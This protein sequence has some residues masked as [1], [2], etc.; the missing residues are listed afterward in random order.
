MLAASAAVFALAVLAALL[1]SLQAG[2]Q[3]GSGDTRITSLEGDVDV[4]F[5]GE[6]EW[7]PAE[8]DT[9]LDAG[10]S[11]KTGAGAQAEISFG[12]QSVYELQQ[13]SELTLA[14]AGAVKTAFQLDVGTLLLHIRKLLTGQ[15]VEVRTKTALAAVIGTELG[16]TVDPDGATDVGVIDGEVL[17]ETKAMPGLPARQIQVAKD[18]ELRIALGAKPEAPRPLKA[19]LPFRDR[20]KRLHARRI[21]LRRDWQSLPPQRRAELRRNLVESRLQRLQKRRERLRRGAPPPPADKPE[22]KGRR[23]PKGGPAQKRRGRGKQR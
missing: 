14:E 8:K 22:L 9:P 18:K 16:V 20:F 11:V 4:R 21:E 1:W 5:K 12:G 17:V 15:G 7:T 6:S 2:A 3:E 10:D 23:A 13:N 19:F